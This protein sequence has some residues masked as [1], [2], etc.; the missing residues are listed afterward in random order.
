LWTTSLGLLVGFEC[1]SWSWPSAS[2]VAVALGLGYLL[3]IWL[4]VGWIVM[5]ERRMVWASLSIFPLD[6]SVSYSFG[7]L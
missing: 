3:C 6:V 5:L 4:G 2:M 7:V 1:E